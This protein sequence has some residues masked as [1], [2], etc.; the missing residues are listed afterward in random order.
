MGLRPCLAPTVDA[1]SGR[2]L[3]WRG[4]SGRP[5]VDYVAVGEH[6]ATDSGATAVTLLWVKSWRR[7]QPRQAAAGRTRPAAPSRHEPRRRHGRPAGHLPGG[8]RADL[9]DQGPQHR[10]HVQ[11]GA[12]PSGRFGP[13]RPQLTGHRWPHTIR[14][15]ARSRG[16]G[17]RTHFESDGDPLDGPAGLTLRCAGPMIGDLRRRRSRPGGSHL[18]N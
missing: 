5:D 4:S 9:R 10:R 15:R 6:L 17:W 13:W 8:R 14:R 18:N 16:P 3:P 11:D 1:R 2:S 12:G 7:R